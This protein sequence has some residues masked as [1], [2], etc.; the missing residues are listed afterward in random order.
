MSEHILTSLV[1]SSEKKQGSP[2]YCASIPVTGSPSNKD[3]KTKADTYSARP[4]HSEHQTGFA[5]DLN[6][7]NRPSK[8]MKTDSAEKLE[9]RRKIEDRCIA[10]ELG[11]NVEDLK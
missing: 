3:G 7:P 11:I 6:I 8:K 10:R 5:M 4:G 9:L 1:T 2:E